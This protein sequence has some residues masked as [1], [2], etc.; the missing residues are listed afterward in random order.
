MSDQQQP[1]TREEV[2]AAIEH[3]KTRETVASL[4]H[5][6]S[7]DW[8]SIFPKL[9]GMGAKGDIR[10]RVVMLKSVEPRLS[11]LLYPDERIELVTKGTINNYLEQ[12]FMGIWSIIINRTLILCT[13]YRIIFVNSDKAGRARALMW[14]IP[15]D[16]LKK[17]GKAM[18]N[19]T[20]KC[21]GGTVL[22]FVAVP[23]VDRKRLKAYFADKIE[24]AQSHGPE[25]PS[26][27][28]RDPL[29]PACATPQEGAPRKCAQCGD[30]FI[31]P[32]VPAL[33]SLVIPGTGDLYLGHH[34]MASI[35]L[36]GFALLLFVSVAL[37]FANGLVVLPG[38]VL[39]IAIANIADAAITFHVARKGLLSKRQIWR[40]T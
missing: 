32:V 23:G 30:E 35:E 15:Y 2:L 4:Q 39:L 38:V 12:Y 20:F 27:S 19:I 37:L 18:G 14:Q 7:Y 40:G 22:R 5:P 21:T 31:N 11:H 17:A 24:H 29:C 36:V 1:G 25:F 33:M 16:R 13:N 8:S 3:E 10:R 34:A 28:D 26:Y 9:Q 6:A